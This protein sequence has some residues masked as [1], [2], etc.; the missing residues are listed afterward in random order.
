MEK[1]IDLIAS[2]QRIINFILKAI[3]SLDLAKSELEKETVDYELVYD[4]VFEIQGYLNAVHRTM[5]AILLKKKSDKD[6][7]NGES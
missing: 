2:K 7:V 3:R 4:Y 6:I 5:R 1:V